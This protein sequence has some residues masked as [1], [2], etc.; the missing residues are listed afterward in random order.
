[1]QDMEDVITWPDGTWCYRHELVEYGYMSDDYIVLK[2]E[3]KEWS[4]FLKD[5]EYVEQRKDK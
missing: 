1:M 3:T 5:N 4:R 2:Y